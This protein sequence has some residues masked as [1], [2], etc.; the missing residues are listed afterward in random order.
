LRCDAQGRGIVLV[1]TQ[2]LEQSLDYDVD[3]MVSDLA[4][5]DLVIQRAGRLWRHPHRNLDRPIG[6][7]ERRLLILSPDQ[8]DVRDKNWY[9]NLSKRAA[10]VYADHGLVWRSAGALFDAGAIRTP[11]GVR[12]LLARV[13]DADRNEDIPE[14]L[15]RSARDAS[16]KEM[17]ARSFANANLLKLRDGYGGNNALWTSDTITPTR[18]GE[19]VTVFRLGRI[20]G[21]RI[22]PWCEADGPARSWAL[23]EVSLRSKVANDVPNQIGAMAKMIAAAKAEWPKW[24]QEQPLLLLE[25]DGDGWRGEV[26]TP[27]KGKRVVLYDIAIGLRVA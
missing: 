5:L 19:P 17:A 6:E 3:A 14:V 2:I 7:A 20:D 9:R 26:N 16:G 23:S 18:L 10:A 1:G 15:E 11:D 21:D 24:E 12:L 27:D 22:V 4:P 8:G 13:Y 25:A